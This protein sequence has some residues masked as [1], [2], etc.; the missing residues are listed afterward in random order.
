MNSLFILIKVTVG[1][2]LRQFEEGA[3]GIHVGEWK[4]LQK[5]GLFPQSEH[6]T[7]LENPWTT[8]EALDNIN[9]L[10][11]FFF[12]GLFQAATVR[13]NSQRPKARLVM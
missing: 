13:I 12:P 8:E 3:A 10:L 2:L 11:V 4:R 9:L 5:G 1:Y 7:V 6:G